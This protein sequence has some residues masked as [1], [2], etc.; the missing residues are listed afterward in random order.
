VKQL[1]SLRNTIDKI[2][3]KIM[4]LL[5]KRQAAVLKIGGMKSKTDLPIRDRVREEEIIGRLT[6][7]SA[8]LDKGFIRRLFAEIMKESRRMQ[9]EHRNLY[10]QP[11]VKGERR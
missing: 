8:A 7:A 6:D 1:K 2:D 10:K 11:K 4:K 3:G 5:E 9:A